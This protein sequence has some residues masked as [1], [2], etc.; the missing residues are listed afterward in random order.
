MIIKKSVEHL[1]ENKMTYWQ[2]FIFAVTYG[3]KCI[4]A[5]LFL[6]SHAVIPALFAKTGS[7]L[8][9]QL[10]KNFTDSK[11]YPKCKEDQNV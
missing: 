9:N 4:K 6:I 3:V 1:K 8:V 11:E 2:H 7:E 10:N 5:G